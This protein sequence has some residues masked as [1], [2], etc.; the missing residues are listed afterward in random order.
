MHLGHL[1]TSALQMQL[2]SGH[3][4]SPTQISQIAGWSLLNISFISSLL[5][6]HIA[7][8]IIIAISGILI[9]IP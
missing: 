3:G 8:T 6:K 7:A 9:F 4:H 2:V 5:M 1:H